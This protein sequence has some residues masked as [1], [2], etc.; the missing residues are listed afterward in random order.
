[1]NPEFKNK[2]LAIILSLVL[3]FSGILSLPG[4]ADD[5]DIEDII[6]NDSTIN[7]MENKLSRLEQQERELKE[8]L[9]EIES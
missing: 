6:N 5:I 9:K 4:L 3:T 1:M 8:K 7:E 2:A